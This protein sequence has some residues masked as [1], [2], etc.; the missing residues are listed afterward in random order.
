MSQPATEQPVQGT[1]E[2]QVT[3]PQ[4]QQ[5]T[6]E[7]KAPYADY[8]EQ[9][10][11]TVRPLVEPT[12]Q[13]WDKNVTQRFQELHSQW[14]PWKE[15]ADQYQP[16]DVIGALQ[17]ALVLDQEPERFLEAFKASYPELVEKMLEGQGGNQQ[18]PTTQTGS[19]QGLGDLDPSD[20]VAKALLQMQEQ[21]QQLT[22]NFTEKQQLEEQEASQKYLDSVLKQLHDDHGDFDDT[23]ILSQM[24]FANKTP[25]QAFQAW[26]DLQAKYLTP[27]Q[28]QQTQTPAPPVIP[29]G[30]GVPT[31]QPQV[32]DLD[33]AKTKNLVAGL[34]EAAAREG[35]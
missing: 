20:P 22:G 13:E 21:L 28:Q 3:D 5:P 1:E 2:T 9:V 11:E 23:F 24:A 25:E 32:E 33:S 27:G 30:G 12:F 31:T 4:Q 7:T 6:Q 26:T 16:E 8:L 15:V 19:E 29:S 10:P 18:Q 35:T 17:M 34:L 14:E